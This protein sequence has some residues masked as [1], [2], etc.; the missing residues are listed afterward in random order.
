MDLPRDN[1]M[2]INISDKAK[3]ELINLNIQGEKFLRLQV[4]SGGCAGK[5]YE[6][7]VDNNLTSDDVV[8]FQEEDFKVIADIKSAFYLNGLQI[9]YSDD[10]INSGF[11]F[12]NPKAKKSCG[13]GSS[14]SA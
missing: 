3:R 12:I 6:A 4:I 1:I 2:I 14:F 5:T 9:D 7:G 11:R 13:C 10:L 8:L